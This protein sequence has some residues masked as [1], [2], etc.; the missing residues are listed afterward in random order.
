MGK[1]EAQISGFVVVKKAPIPLKKILQK[2]KF[3]QLIC[4]DMIFKMVS[5]YSFLNKWVSRY[6]CFSD[7]N[8]P[9]NCTSQ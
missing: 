6:L 1:N 5:G 7:F 4:A 9:K 2:K 3:F 8:V